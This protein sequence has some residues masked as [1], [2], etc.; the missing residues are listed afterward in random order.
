MKIL[1]LGKF[2][3]VKGGIEKVMYDIMIGL[4]ERGID[5]DM[6]CAESVGHGNVRSV[7]P[8][9]RLLTHR[10]WIKAASTTIAPSMTVL[11]R[12]IANDYDI[13]HIHHPDPMAAL[14][15]RLSGFKGKVV[16]H[17]H[18]DIVK[19][20]KL[21]RLFEPLQKWLIGRADVV[22]GTSPAYLRHSVHLQRA[23]SKSVCLPI[24]IEPV[25]PDS[26]GAEKIRSRYQGKK[27]VF[28]LGRL[29]P[30]K[31][32]PFLIEA[33]SMLPDDYVVLLGGEGPLHDS[34]LSQVETLGLNS[35]VIM[36]GEIPQ[37]ELPAY[38]TAC[39]LFCLPSVMKSE[40]FGIVS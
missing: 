28:F 16:L 33:A 25:E 37:E 2:Y 4:A 31:G 24:G 12:K 5:C 23:A 9:A 39:D 6:M 26:E 14:A 32:L 20:K 40:A 29:I 35:K 8:H 22:V 38:Y 15:L 21:F 1:Q 11:L 10:T 13:I 3:P 18:S 19:Q 36:L 27:I 7:T 17:W 30:Y 34:L